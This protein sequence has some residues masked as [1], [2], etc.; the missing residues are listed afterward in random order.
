MQ[1]FGWQ[2]R[3]ADEPD[4]EKLQAI[5]P[6]VE[7]DGAL[8]IQSGGN[9]GTYVDLEGSAKTEAELVNKYREMSLHPE[10]DSAIDDI[11]NESI[12][13]EK[14]QDIVR[15]NM[16]ALKN[17]PP[18]VKD[19][20]SQ[21]F[22]NILALLNF[23]Q[24][25]YD[26]FRRWYVDGRLYYQAI[27]DVTKPQEGIS[28]LRY[29]DPRKIRKVREIKESKQQLDNKQNGGNIQS[30]KKTEVVNEFFIYNEKGF[31]AKTGTIGSQTSA[32]QSGTR[33]TK[34][35]ILHITSGILDVAS[36]VVLSHL[37]KAIKPLNQLRAIEDASVIYRLARAPERRVFNIDVGNL[38]KI[39]AEQYMRD[40]MTRYKNKIVYD[41]STGEI[42]DDRK[43]MTMLED[44]WLPKRDG[45]G[46]T[47]DT[48]PGGE[49]LGEMTDVEY[50]QKKLYRSLNVPQSRLESESVFSLGQG[51]EIT[52]DEV[53]FAKFVD[54]LRTRFDQLFLGAL[55][56]QVV[57]KGIMQSGEW[58]LFV[59][60]IKFDYA[61]DNYY[62][63]LKDSQITASRAQNLALV[64][65]FIGLYVSNNWARKEILRQSEDQIIQE[66]QLIMQEMKNPIYQMASQA[67]QMPAHAA[68]ADSTNKKAKSSK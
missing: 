41:A 57:L 1:F 40:V 31:A 16:E 14:T 8:V 12:V 68:L 28:E 11:V 36:S 24:L 65:P 44:F 4:T 27:I 39:K 43:F 21:E 50:F 45:K 35:S 54:R 62:S 49:N 51:S 37:H 15:I 67:Y 64:Q 23:N 53:K 52:R 46:T 66:D 20:I 25:G 10:V 30:L 26:V 59:D 9:Y 7:D 13:V 17:I 63:E 48:L 34:D 2:I 18:K 47:I 38:P 32:G 29:I 61:R 56:K 58:D 60:K 22:D 42:R 5:S 33:I 19:M 55:G 3:R 6:P